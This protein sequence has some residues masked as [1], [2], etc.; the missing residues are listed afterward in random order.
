M[1]SKP[2]ILVNFHETWFESNQENHTW[3]PMNPNPW[4]FELISAPPC[5]EENVIRFVKS[6]PFNFELRNLV[7]SHIRNQHS[8]FN[9]TFFLIGSVFVEDPR[10]FQL[11]KEVQRFNDFIIGDYIDAYKNVTRKSFSAYR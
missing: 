11:E 7:R 10:K 5:P 9:K 1:L 2:K 6:S 4:D 8:Q 3:N